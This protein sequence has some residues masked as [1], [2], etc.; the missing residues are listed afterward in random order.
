M[1]KVLKPT[2]TKEEYEKE[3][4]E[5][6][7]RELANL[8][9]VLNERLKK[10]IIEKSDTDR[11]Y[12]LNDDSDDMG[13][14]DE[15]LVVKRKSKKSNK[16]QNDNKLIDVIIKNQKLK[17]HINKLETQIKFLQLDVTNLNVE[18]DLLVQDNKKFKNLKKIFEIFQSDENFLFS[19]ESEYKKIMNTNY[20]S[21][22]PALI[23]LQN[24]L[25]NHPFDAHM[26]DLNF[27][28]SNFDMADNIFVN[29]I[30]NR[31]NELILKHTQIEKLMSETL[32]KSEF[33]TYRFMILLTLVIAFM[34]FS[35]IVLY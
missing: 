31:K 32:A 23:L 3:M 2:K 21:R 27:L 16:N 25:K 24:N 30:N 7:E 33:F 17:S 9:K 28:P 8:N 15:S 5:T 4:K 11:D 1:S 35:I 29:T 19:I 34:L 12:S 6:T 26:A 14:S 18:K 20:F 13:S 10:E 22:N